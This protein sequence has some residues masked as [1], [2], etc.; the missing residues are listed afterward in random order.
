MKV[1]AEFEMTHEDQ[2]RSV[3]L[4]RG[5]RGGGC[6]FVHL[7]AWLVRG[8]RGGQIAGKRKKN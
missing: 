5:G 8:M 2:G 1:Y 3:D 7:P 4:V 6:Y